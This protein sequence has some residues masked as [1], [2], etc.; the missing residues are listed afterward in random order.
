M[1][2]TLNAL[3]RGTLALACLTL[4]LAQPAPCAGPKQKAPKP[5]ASQAAPVPGKAFD[6]YRGQPDMTEDE[7]VRFAGDI[8]SFRDTLKNRGPVTEWRKNRE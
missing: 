8:G 6:V 2:Y 5:A 7:I 4:C 1:Q 3:A